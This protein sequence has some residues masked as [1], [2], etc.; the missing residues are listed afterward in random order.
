MLF[1]IA[2]PFRSQR[3]S[4]LPPSGQAAHLR[5]LPLWGLLAALRLKTLELDSS[6][7]NLWGRLA[8][9]AKKS[10]SLERLRSFQGECLLYCAQKPCFATPFGTIQD[11]CLLRCAQKPYIIKAQALQAGLLQPSLRV[12][13]FVPTFQCFDITTSASHSMT[14]MLCII[15]QRVLRNSPRKMRNCKNIIGGASSCVPS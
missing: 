13:I 4:A 11:E 10:C 15:S 5:V 3:A 8:S 14:S 7:V 2:A 9:L 12:I 1:K 6:W